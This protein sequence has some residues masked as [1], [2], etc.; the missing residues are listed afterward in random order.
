MCV[1]CRVA[2][3]RAGWVGGP[4]AGHT[5]QL[6]LSKSVADGVCRG[7]KAAIALATLVGKPRCHPHAVSTLQQSRSAPPPKHHWCRNRYLLRFLAAQQRKTRRTAIGRQQ[8]GNLE[9]RN[10]LAGH[11]VQGLQR[12][13]IHDHGIR[14]VHPNLARNQL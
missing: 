5:Q 13:S 10:R 9:A 6:Q 7:N 14:S 1:G 3:V 4:V 8:R 12:F 2:S 11:G